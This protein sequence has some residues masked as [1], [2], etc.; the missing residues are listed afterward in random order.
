MGRMKG[1][2]AAFLVATVLAAAAAAFA[3]QEFTLAGGT[4]AVLE[5]RRLV[6]IGENS[7]R[8][9]APIGVYRI[10]ESDREIHVTG[11]GA[12]VRKRLPEIR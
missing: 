11:E 10:R 8:V 3:A 4:R 6:L 2:I 12:E 9:V 1:F 7:E 5:G